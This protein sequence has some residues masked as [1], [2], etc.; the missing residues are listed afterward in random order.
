MARISVTNLPLAPVSSRANL[1]FA[2]V[3]RQ[4]H[5]WKRYWGWEVV[6]LAYGVVNTLAITFIAEQVG[7][8]G[9]AAEDEVRD[10][11]LFLL[12]GTLVWAYISAVLDDVS[13]VIIWERWEGTIEHTLM[14]P[15]PRWLHLL[16][17]SC[18][19]LAHAI[20]RTSLIFLLAIP[21]FSIDLS[22]A[23]WTAAALVIGV[24][25]VNVVGIAILGGV[26]PLLY[27]E[28]G[29]Q[30]T[31]M[32]QSVILLVSGVYYTIDVLPAWLRSLAVIS[33]ATYIL[34]GIRGSMIE[35]KSI[36]DLQGGLLALVLS[37]VILVP[38]SLAVFAVAEHWAKK[39]G[40]LKRQG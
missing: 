15:V 3:E 12:T 6:W 35:G 34:E 33:P 28:R 40:K 21:F 39:T 11:V 38:G 9:I 1:V 14:A 5:L 10:L 17:M 19:G 20:I 22:Q 2:F 16:G 23:N 37:G 13:M 36:A 30:M 27:P 25:S 4:T 31:F 7:Y 29:A 26:L 8:A 24:G 32:L 18:F